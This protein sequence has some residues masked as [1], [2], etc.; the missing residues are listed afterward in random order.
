M[1]SKRGKQ[2]LPI[3]PQLAQIER[4]SHDARGIARIDGKVTFISNALP[5][6]AVNFQYTRVKK[7]FAEG[8]MLSIITSSSSRVEPYCAHYTLCGGCSLQHLDTQAQTKEKQTLLIDMLK[9]LGHCEPKRW[10]NPLVGPAWHY[11]HKARLSVRYVE[12]KQATLVGFREKHN[13]RFI[14]EI[15]QCPI[16]AQPIADRILDL[17]KLIDSFVEPQVIAQIEVAVGDNEVALVFRNLKSLNEA[18][19]AKLRQFGEETAFRLFL[20]PGGSDSVEAFYPNDA[21]E[22]LTYRLPELG[23]SFYFHPTDFTQ[24]NRA[25]NRLMVAQAMQL[26]DTKPNDVV[27]DLF[28][29]LGN[30]A[31]PLAL[32]CAKVIGVEVCERMV[33]RARM[34][35]EANNL[36][37]CE[38]VCAD[39]QKKEAVSWLATFGCNKLLIDPP[40]T[41]ALALVEE[42]DQLS[43]E[44]LVYVS[45]N[46]A[47]LARDANILVN[48]KGYQLSAVGIV[49]MFPHTAHIE[50]IAL[51]E[52]G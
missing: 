36:I 19:E 14:T 10:L 30:F 29:G 35:A 18:D 6:E 23:L 12:K 38:F 24:I 20:Q 3:T 25:L 40:R 7:D 17:R 43:I 2:N 11:R 44:R 27:L 15:S 51:F 41:G 28:C 52:K 39:L 50:S 33:A 22:F 31:L 42:I 5:G 4:F 8:K 13:P 34:N 37:N 26:M 45:C 9:R 47:T 16:L 21:N 1:S 49:D 48:Q 32:Q 46:P